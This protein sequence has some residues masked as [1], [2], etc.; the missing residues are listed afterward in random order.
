[1]QLVSLLAAPLLLAG[2]LVA[3]HGG[4]IR[5]TIDGKAYDTATIGSGATRL[6]A[7]P[8]G[9][10]NF[11]RP[12]VALNPVL[13]STSPNM[14]CNAPGTPVKFMLNAQAGSEIKAQW[15][16]W[17]HDGGPLSVW[18]T[19]CP[20]D[21]S[22][23]TNAHTAQWFKIHDAGM[24]GAQKLIRAGNS[25]TVTIPSTLKAGNYLI[26]HEIINLARPPA[27]FY[28]ECA[29]LAV[30]GAGTVSPGPEFRSTLANA[31]KMGSPELSQSYNY[32]KTKPGYK[33]PGPEPYTG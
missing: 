21:C 30:G 17:P 20:G 5:Y 4:V 10:D 32:W 11:Q 18:M 22:T 29:Q 8:K 6:R 26:R 24:E 9:G 28:P 3:A 15:N 14:A 12:W 27:E 25:L 2:S 19:E 33:F 7:T 31:Y 13:S 16:P 1:M 23:F